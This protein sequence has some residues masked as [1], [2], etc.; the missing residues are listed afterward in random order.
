MNSHSHIDTSS[1]TLPV[2]P[3]L[4]QLV[5][6]GKVPEWDFSNLV[7]RVCPACLNDDNVDICQRPDRL[8]VSKCTQCEMI[9]LPLIPS[10]EQL[11]RF[12]S[13]YS[14]YKVFSPPS[15]LYRIFKFNSQN[16]HLNILLS[17]GGIRGKKICEIGCSYGHFL[18]LCR[19]RNASVLG[20]EWD[21]E[22]IEY[23]RNN[24]IATA[25]ELPQDIKFDIK[26]YIKFRLNP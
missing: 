20:V 26:F 17:T 12:Y 21:K 11:R 25:I 1:K 24:N 14:T 18:D 9:Y 8:V 4:P 6:A 23:L 22:A 2:L 5:F 13:V 19:Q 10:N 3:P 15:L 7:H 16:P